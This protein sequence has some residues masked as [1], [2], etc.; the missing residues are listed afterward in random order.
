[1][2]TPAD[3]VIVLV[4][5]IDAAARAY[6]TLGFTVQTRADAEV[7][8]AYYRCITLADGSY[9]L[10]T[11]FISEEVIAKHRLGPDL[12]EGEGFADWS[13]TVADVEATRA[14]LAAAGGKTC[15]PV[16]V[17]N[18]LADGS[19]WGLKLLMTG[20][21]TEGDD[22]LPFVVEDTHGREFRIPGYKPHANGVTHIREIRASSEHP[23]E[24]ARLLG[25]VM[26][27]PVEGT[28]VM[29]DPAPVVF[30][31]VREAGTAARKRGGIYELVLAGG[32]AAGLMDL[33][34][35]HG[36]RLIRG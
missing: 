6:E 21:G 1:M 10:L 3:H 5:D 36:A 23:A 35:A 30:A 8:G 25:V 16:T 17:S 24:S 28:T 2:P 20:K 22:A 18:V 31:S 27:A 7:H 29:A 14:D 12:A 9:I 34:L 4:N 15:G 32:E 19:P 11:Q 33:D 26:Q 13:F